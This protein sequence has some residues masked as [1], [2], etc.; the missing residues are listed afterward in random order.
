MRREISLIKSLTK[1][2]GLKRVE[3][4]LSNRESGGKLKKKKSE[5]FKGKKYDK[6]L[7]SSG[8]HVASC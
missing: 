5:R 7:D 3:E 2:S 4:K 1:Q 8:S 6:V